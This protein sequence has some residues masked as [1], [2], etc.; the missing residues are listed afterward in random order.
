MDLFAAIR[1][2][3][4][5]KRRIDRL[6]A[7]LEARQNGTFPRSRRGRKGMGEEE[8]RQVSERMRSYWQERR[9]DASEPPSAS[10]AKTN[11]ASATLTTSA[12]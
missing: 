10:V 4:A 8:R 6:I 11:D 2:L 1:D 5:E 12:S 7:M 3:L 9:K